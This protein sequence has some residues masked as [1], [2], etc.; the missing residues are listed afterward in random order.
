MCRDRTHARMHERTHA[1]L[2]R[3]KLR[4]NIMCAYKPHGQTGRE[5]MRHTHTHTQTDRQ[6]DRQTESHTLN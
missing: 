5:D 4:L 2:G 1:L 3:I 6:T